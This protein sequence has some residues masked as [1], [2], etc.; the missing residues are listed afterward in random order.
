MKT[1]QQ[2]LNE[3][4]AEEIEHAFFYKHP[5]KLMDGE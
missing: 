1:I 2:V 4:A 3:L 5:I